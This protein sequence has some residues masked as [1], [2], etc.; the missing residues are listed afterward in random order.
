[1]NFNCLDEVSYKRQTGTIVG[2]RYG[3]SKDMY[4]GR[5]YDVKIQRGQHVE[6]LKDIREMELSRVAPAIETESYKY[7]MTASPFKPE[8]VKG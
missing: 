3:H 7:I 1:M 8:L 6:I 4:A 2:K 5:L